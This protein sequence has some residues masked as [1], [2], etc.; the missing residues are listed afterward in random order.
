MENSVLKKYPQDSAGSRMISNVPIC[1]SQSTVSEVK[2]TIFKEASH[3]DTLNYVYVVDDGKL[4]GVFS[5]KEIFK[6]QGDIKVKSFMETA[7]VNAGPEDDQE[8]VAILAIKHE[9]KAIPIIKKNREFLG[10]IPSDVILDILH[11]E[12]VEDVL[13]AAGLYKVKDFSTKINELSSKILAKMRLP[14]LIIG[15]FGGILAAEVVTL[16]EGPLSE[17]FILAAFIPLIV[18]MSAA[19]G[20][21][22]QTLYVRSIAINHISHKNYFFKEVRVGFLVASILALIL[23]LMGSLIANNFLIGLI[24]GIA[25]FLTIIFSMSISVFIVWLLSKSKKDPAF[26]SGPFGTIISDISSL[27]IY[28]IIASFL[29]NW[30]K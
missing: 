6:K 29:L 2:E 14:W 13:Y 4:V 11:K 8:K 20:S 3:L 10:I 12:H 26:G 9:L 1:N 30:L 25:L 27:I 19:A 16:F 28:F 23:F 21:Q 18:Y 17:H 15:L 24:L 22:T 7:V 5:I